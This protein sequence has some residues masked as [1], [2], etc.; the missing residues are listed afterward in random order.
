MGA[1]TIAYPAPVYIVGT[2]DDQDRPNAMAAAWAGICCSKPP[3][4]AVSLRQ[5]TYTYGNIRSRREFTVSIPSI[6][7]VREADYF[8]LASGRDTDK[9]E[10]TGLTPVKAEHVNAPYV[11]EFPLVLECRLIHVLEIGL[12]TQFV[13]EIVDVKADEECIDERAKVRVEAVRPFAFCP[14]VHHYYALGEDLGRAF[15]IG[16]EVE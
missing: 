3:C 13:G 7:H 12:H 2:Y 5:A 1:R 8:G 14:D 10:V 16:R 15:R 11:E 4:L 6:D 9:F